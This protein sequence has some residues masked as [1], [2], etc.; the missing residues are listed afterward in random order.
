MNCYVDAGRI[1]ELLSIATADVA[2]ALVIADAASRIA[3]QMTGRHFYTE[4]ATRYYDGT[5]RDTLPVHDLLALTSLKTDADLDE[6]YSETWVKGTDFEVIPD[7]GY[8]WTAIRRKRGDSLFKLYA[9]S[10]DQ[11]NWIQIVG[12]FGAGDM[13]S[14]DPWAS[15]GI[16]GTVASTTGTTLTLSNGDGVTAGYT[17]K[18]GTEQMFVT[19]RSGHS[20]TVVRGVNGT[21]ATTHSAV[22]VYKAVY[23]ASIVNGTEAVAGILHRNIGSAGMIQETIKNYSYMRSTAANEDAQI[24]RIFSNLRREPWF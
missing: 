11:T 6:T 14:A 23:P 22:A 13:M 1:S 21:T 12:T 2:D 17:L 18:L 16:T 9:P 20:A 3:D 8:P 19:A 15:L 10:T 4:T 5:E 24:R 7:A